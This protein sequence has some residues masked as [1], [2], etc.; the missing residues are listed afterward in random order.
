MV[1]MNVSKTA[2]SCLKTAY[3][4]STKTDVDQVGTR[5]ECA[6]CMGTARAD[7]SFVRYISDFV[8]RDSWAIIKKNMP[9][10]SDAEMAEIIN[11][12][13]TLDTIFAGN[14]LVALD[15]TS[16]AGVL[17][18]VKFLNAASTYNPDIGDALLYAIRRTSNVDALTDYRL[19][20]S[21]AASFFNKSGPEA[22]SEWFYSIGLTRNVDV[23]TSD[24]V[25]SDAVLAVINKDGRLASEYSLAVGVTGDLD[26]LAN[27]GLLNSLKGLKEPLRAEVLSGVW[28]TKSAG[29]I[30]PAVVG[31]IGTG[32]L[33]V[34]RDF[35]RAP[36]NMGLPRVVFVGLND[37]H[38]RG[39]K[40]IAQSMRDSGFDVIYLDD[41][42]SEEIVR[43]AKK[44][45]VSAIGFS[46]MADSY[47]HTMD[48]VLRQLG[49]QCES[50]VTVFCG[51]TVS[52]RTSDW[53]QQ[54]GVH[55]FERGTSE[56]ALIGFLKGS[57]QLHHPPLPYVPDN[58]GQRAV[59]S[60]HQTPFNAYLRSENVFGAP[61][62]LSDIDDEQKKTEK[63][64]A[65]VVA[66]DRAS[67]QN[68]H[69]NAYKDAM[70]IGSNAISLD[71]VVARM[72]NSQAMVVKAMPASLFNE[73]SILAA[74]A[75]NT[76]VHLKTE[77]YGVH[78]QTN[79]VHYAEVRSYTGP[80][81]VPISMQMCGHDAGAT[82][83]TTPLL[84]IPSS[85]TFRLC[86]SPRYL[87]LV[88]VSASALRGDTVFAGRTLPA[89]SPFMPAAKQHLAKRSLRMSERIIHIIRRFKRFS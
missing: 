65:R 73:E 49:A 77:V 20:T 1:W 43:I 80:G 53:L 31:K 47:R 33:D 69:K 15:A 21:N 86:N 29:W 75:A 50:A 5:L 19:F 71:I 88:N 58:I 70:V 8:N 23:L 3:T 41:A 25:L 68:A 2:D 45:S 76:G 83:T 60:G 56:N 67:V 48:E 22:A 17:T 52:Q 9:D 85:S 32:E 40:L 35:A 44:E 87:E 18:S 4:S 7:S 78:E 37:G 13:K 27:T 89:I 30:T 57:T 24:R 26:A 42:S 10:S 72:P 12:I 59:S 54:V 51:G 64:I 46:L 14:L 82:L 38:N 11:R 55:L 6:C 74:A 84:V 62:A 36:A 81:A 28:Y 16:D 61:F 63:T 66:I 34:W 79:I 39:S